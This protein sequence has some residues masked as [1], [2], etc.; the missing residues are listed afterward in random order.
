MRAVINLV[1]LENGGIGFSV[2][3]EKQAEDTGI[4]DAGYLVHQLTQTLQLIGINTQHRQP[5]IDAELAQAFIRRPYL[6]GAQ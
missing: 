4:T 5:R 1:D 3:S 2:Q 6:K